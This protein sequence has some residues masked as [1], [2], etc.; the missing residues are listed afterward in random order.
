MLTQNNLDN[1]R[2]YHI[3]PTFYVRQDNMSN[4]ITYFHYG[5]L[6]SYEKLPSFIQTVAVWKVKKLK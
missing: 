2:T 3:T 4:G 1:F 5:I 6:Y